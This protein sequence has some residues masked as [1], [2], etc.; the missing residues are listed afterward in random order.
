[1]IRQG[2]EMQ[3]LS[4][5]NGTKKSNG[6]GPEYYD[7][8]INHDMEIDDQQ[9]QN[10]NWDRMDTDQPPLDTQPEYL[11]LV[12]ET[13][14][15]GKTLQ[16]EFKDDPRRE[17][18]KALEDA[19]ALIAY[20]DPLSMPSV[21]HL[22]DIGGREAVADE[23]NSA[24]LCK[25]L[26][27]TPSCDHSPSDIPYVVSLGKSSSTALEQLYQ[28]TSVLLDDLREGGGPGAFVNIDDFVKVP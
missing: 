24:I 2:A 1:M 9:G 25:S 7:D 13:I 15:Y 16:A 26:Y 4:S 8:F 11:R 6:H 10:N 21:S 27:L 18:R 19:F 17:V 14:T 12:Q 3:R 20:S 23:L 5:T 22:L 28:Q